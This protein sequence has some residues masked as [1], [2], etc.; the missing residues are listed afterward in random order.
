MRL[1]GRAAC[2]ELLLLRHSCRFMRRH[3]DLW[4]SRMGNPLRYLGIEVDNALA[5]AEPFDV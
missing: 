1:Q 3:L 4:L 2:R 5:I